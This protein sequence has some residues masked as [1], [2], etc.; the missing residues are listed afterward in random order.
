MGGVGYAARCIYANILILGI[1]F[2][3][4][5]KRVP[6]GGGWHCPISPAPVVSLTVML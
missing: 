5:D 2:S 4:L 1:D 6:G 3:S